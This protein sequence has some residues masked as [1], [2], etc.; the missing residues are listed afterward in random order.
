MRKQVIHLVEPINTVPFE[1]LKTT[2]M[3]QYEYLTNY[4]QLGQHSGMSL[5]NFSEF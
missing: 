5:A 2:D 3:L 4:K 1:H